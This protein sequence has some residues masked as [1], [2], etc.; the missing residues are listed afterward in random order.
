[1]FKFR[2]AETG[3]LPDAGYLAAQGADSILDLSK[4]IPFPPDLA[5]EVASPSQGAD[6]MAAKARQYL[7]GGTTLVWVFWPER[8][9]VDVWRRDALRPRHQ[10]MRPSATLYVSAGDALDGEDVVPGFSYPLAP[11]FVMPRRRA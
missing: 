11:L 1:V 3:L 9:E 8:G 5:A 4:P 6:A 10:D 2:G 7:D